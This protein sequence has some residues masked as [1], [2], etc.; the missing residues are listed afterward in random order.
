[1]STSV[2]SSPP[3]PP[4]PPPPF[5]RLNKI[6]KHQTANNRRKQ[7]HS[8]VTH[9]ARELVKLAIGA[10]KLRRLGGRRGRVGEGEQGRPEGRK[11]TMP[12]PWAASSGVWLWSY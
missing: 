8:T 9:H 5:P 3:P 1:M 2:T 6:S 12:E 4:P 10:L 11:G 7:S